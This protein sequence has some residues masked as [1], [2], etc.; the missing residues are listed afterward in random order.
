MNELCRRFVLIIAILCF[1]FAVSAQNGGSFVTV[2]YQ[3][4]TLK[5][6]LDDISSQTGFLFVYNSSQV[7]DKVTLDIKVKHKDLEQV[8]TKISE[9]LDFQYIITE[10]QI[11]LKPRRTEV[12][13][14]EG[15]NSKLPVISGYVRDFKTKE[16]LIGATISVEGKNI[17]T[18]T[19]AYGYYSLPLSRGE[20]TFIYSYLG[21]KREYVKVVLSGSVDIN[22]ELEETEN[23]IEAISISGGGNNA[24]PK[25]SLGKSGSSINV[26]CF[27]QYSGLVLGGDLAGI[28]AT[29]HGITR[30][31]DGSAF[32]SVRGGGKDQ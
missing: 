14:K 28:L 6:V 25:E 8:L 27:A 3:K 31:S 16:V 19:N 23:T 7:D 20:Y 10:K 24:G 22:K 21:Y 18:A 9:I 29:D 26:K 13:T 1:N 4:G 17:G 15:D 2:S 32:Y 11:I 12:R 30:L 5:D